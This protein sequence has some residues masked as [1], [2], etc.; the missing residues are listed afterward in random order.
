[1]RSGATAYF[2]RPILPLVRILVCCSKQ[3][4][5]RVLALARRSE[6]RAV[7][8]AF[9][10]FQIQ[11]QIHPNASSNFGR[12]AVKRQLVY[13]TDEPINLKIAPT[14]GVDF[15]ALYKFALMNT[16]NDDGMSP[17]AASK[18]FGTIATLPKPPTPSFS[19]C[20]IAKS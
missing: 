3:E 20:S 10:K 12:R 8:C 18:L 13:G 11:F 15:T 17:Y 14:V 4:S 7:R 16:M 1:V 9:L 5:A 6:G 19:F 2:P